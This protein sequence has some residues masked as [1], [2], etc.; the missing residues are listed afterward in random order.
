MK[1]Q[2]ILSALALAIIGLTLPIQ[3]FAADKPAKPDAPAARR[4]S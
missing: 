1:K 3:S 4:A 2:T